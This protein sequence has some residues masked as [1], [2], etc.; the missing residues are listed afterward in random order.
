M[1]AEDLMPCG[2]CPVCHE[3]V[4][5]SEA[6]FCDTC[7]APFHWGDCGGWVDGKHMCDLCKD[8]LPY[9][10]TKGKL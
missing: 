2:E 5:H 4:D 1:D 8:E 6:G 10:R 9:V 7:G 3:T